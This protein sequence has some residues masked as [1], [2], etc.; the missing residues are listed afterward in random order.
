MIR[1]HI[2][3]SVHIEKE[4]LDYV[5]FDGKGGVGKMVQ[6]FGD[7]MDPIIDEMNEALAA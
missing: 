7:E 6:L 4:D 5:P 1:D 2:I 3:S